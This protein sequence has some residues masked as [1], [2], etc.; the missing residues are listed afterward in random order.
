[1]TA[2]KKETEPINP[3]NGGSAPAFVDKNLRITAVTSDPLIDIDGDGKLDKDLLPYL[4]PCD[5]DNTIRFEKSGR[6]SGTSGATNC[7]DGSEQATD[8]KPGTWTYNA[9]SHVLRLITT[10][11]SK[12]SVSEWEILE[13]SASG[14]KAKVSAEG[15]TDDFRL[16]MTWKA[17]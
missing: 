6:L 15:S 3:N 16:I 11:D 1:M 10:V 13:E 9:N 8:S 14:L 5:L 4:R 12:Q 2:C 17:Q 7:N